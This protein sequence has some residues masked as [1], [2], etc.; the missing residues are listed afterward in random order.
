MHCLRARRRRACV[1][2]CGK[3]TPQPRRFWRDAR[4]SCGRQ[5]T[6]PSSLPF[7]A[8]HRRLFWILR[9]SSF[10]TPVNN[11]TSLTPISICLFI[12]ELSWPWSFKTEVALICTQAWCASSR[13]ASPL[14]EIQIGK[15]NCALCYFTCVFPC[16]F[17]VLLDSFLLAL[18]RYTK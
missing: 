15:H 17:Y 12:L 4:A 9:A 3:L 7:S 11:R 10:S 2:T 13:P 16:Q 8:P 1:P 18:W 14:S 5:R 6:P